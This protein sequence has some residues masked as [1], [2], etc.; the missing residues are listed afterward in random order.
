MGFRFRKSI[1]VA[2]GV[3]VN[4]G[5]KSGSVSIGTKGAR[6]TVS[7]TGKRTTTVGVPG[8]GLSHVSTS[9]KRKSKGK[10]VSVSG[11][12]YASSPRRSD[13]IYGIIFLVLAAAAFLIGLPTLAFGGWI[14]LLIGVPCLLLGWRYIKL[15]KE[16]SAQ[17][18]EPEA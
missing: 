8:T 2:P 5:K 18:T 4:L 17:N 6:Y 12:S 3:R 11:S 16:L 14:F 15:S 9:S 1:K 10:P 13:K 7:S